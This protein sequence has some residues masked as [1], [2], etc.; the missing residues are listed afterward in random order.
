M[1]SL[2]AVACA[3]YS[4]LPPVGSGVDVARS[5]TVRSSNV[6]ASGIDDASLSVR[7]ALMH[8]SVELQVNAF[9]LVK[10]HPCANYLSESW[11]SFLERNEHKG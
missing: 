2:C 10:A 7:D 4:P 11:A 6:V 1:L 9:A 3:A 8:R 5:H